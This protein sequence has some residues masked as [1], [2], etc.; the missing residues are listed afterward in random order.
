VTAVP[1]AVTTTI[2]T[3]IKLPQMQI[4]EKRVKTEL[5]PCKPADFDFAFHAKKDA[6]GSHIAEKW[7]WDEEYQ[8]SLHQQRWQEKPWFVIMLKGQKIGTVSIQQL[9]NSVRFGEFYLLA[10]YRNKGIGTA[11]I[12]EFLQDCDKQKIKVVLEYLK[13]NPVGA[14]YKRHGF[15]VVSENDIHYFMER[16]PKRLGV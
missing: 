15:K 8:L 11:I 10:D 2:H 6:M 9:E 5:R 14:M 4:F 1:N 13:W 16:E 7:G 12:K 3:A